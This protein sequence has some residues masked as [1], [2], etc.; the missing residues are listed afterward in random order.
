MLFS[1]LEVMWPYIFDKYLLHFY[2][3][4]QEIIYKLMLFTDPQFQNT[5]CWTDTN[6][7][8]KCREY[9]MAFSNVWRWLPS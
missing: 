3:K 6:L 1:R 9:I 7:R 8:F 5:K 2:H 4:D